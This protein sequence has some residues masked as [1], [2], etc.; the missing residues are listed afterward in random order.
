MN[1]FFIIFYTRRFKQEGVVTLDTFFITMY[2][3]IP[4]IFMLP[5]SYSELNALIST[6]E[7]HYLYTPYIDNAFYICS[8]GLAF[9]SAGAA[10][11][12]RWPLSL[13]GYN[14]SQSAFHN[15]IITRVGVITI[16]AS[17]LFITSI[18]FFLGFELGNARGFAMQNAS[19]RPLY[20][21]FHILTPFS[22]LCCLTYGYKKSSTFFYVIGTLITLLGLVSGTRAASIG[23][24][25]SF[26]IMLGIITRY[27]N[28]LIVGCIILFLCTS[29]IYIGG[30][31]SGIY[32]LRKVMML[33]TLI[34]Y[35]NNFSDLRD[36]AWTLSGWDGVYL[37]GRT[38][39]AGA[40]SF[41]PSSLSDYRST[42]N[43]AS[44]SLRSSGLGSISEHAGLRTTVFGEA[45]FN[46][47][48]PGVALIGLMLGVIITRLT[49]I[50]RNNIN[51]FGPRKS[52]VT[53]FGAITYIELM[54]SLV[55]TSG[56]FGFYITLGIIF[57]ACIVKQAILP[58]RTNTCT[59]H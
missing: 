28:I 42:W 10:L 47:G 52:I 24:A 18:M 26:T 55:N 3:Y 7:Y 43:W 57:F 14:F 31:R 20:N 16:A 30:F 50:I 6:G 48:L 29:A 11:A 54:L 27:R 33:P 25:I 34:L 56:F 32:D 37:Q 46:F 58:L 9:F 19:L 2:L 5:F 49:Y 35:G 22:A 39:L 23:V 8:F 41:I 21:L 38:Y 15:V 4:I 40:I 44:F 51:R 36:F 12:K 17:A 45:F 53:V 1:A 59:S 13:P